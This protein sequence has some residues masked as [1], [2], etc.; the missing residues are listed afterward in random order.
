M[1]VVKLTLSDEREKKDQ[2]QVFKGLNKDQIWIQIEILNFRIISETSYL[3]HLK[4]EM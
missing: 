4:F 2:S 3:K 1:L